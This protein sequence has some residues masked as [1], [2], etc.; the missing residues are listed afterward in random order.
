ML[1]LNLFHWQV[2]SPEFKRQ[3]RSKK[4]G[5]D[6]CNSES[7]KHSK[8]TW[9]HLFRSLQIGCVGY[10]HDLAF[11]LSLEWHTRAKHTP[12]QQITGS[13]SKVRFVKALQIHTGPEC[14][15]FLQSSIITP[16]LL[17]DHKLL[18]WTEEFSSPKFI[19]WQP[20]PT[21]MWL[22]LEIKHL[23]GKKKIKWSHKSGIP[24]Q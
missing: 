11:K 17:T 10:S 6:K 23:G 1:A 13:S 24:L 22:Y 2:Q 5:L 19:C 18:L 16:Y 21:S 15:H 8:D 12:A 3:Y 4:S 14:V 20:N 9:C 7:P